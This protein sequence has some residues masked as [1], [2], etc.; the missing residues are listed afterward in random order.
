MN[1]NKN[2]SK[3][4]INN[5]VHGTG[6]NRA[7]QVA[8][9]IY[10]IIIGFRDRCYNSKRE[11]TMGDVRRIWL[12]QVHRLRWCKCSFYWFIELCFHFK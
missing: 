7:H 9:D 1:K 6:M 8:C 12:V 10:I 5:N 2:K 3:N 4:K 11:R